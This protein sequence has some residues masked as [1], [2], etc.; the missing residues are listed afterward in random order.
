M[1]EWIDIFDLILT[2]IY[3]IIILFI[4]YVYKNFRVKSVKEEEYKYFMPALICKV[5]GAISICL[6]YTFYYTY[7]GD[8]T[9]YF[10]TSKT[11]VNTLYSGDFELFTNM[12]NVYDN[13]LNTG[14]LQKDYGS[15]YF[16]HNDYYALF[17]S[18]LIIPFCILGAKT[19]IPTTLLLSC[20]SFIGVWK[21]YRVFIEQFPNLKKEFAIGILFMP[22]V[23]FWGS[24]LLK[25]TFAIAC[26]GFY[27][28]GIYNFFI[29]NNKNMKYFLL[30]SF[31]SILILFIKPYILM[32]LLP[33][34]LI[35]VNFNRIQNVK[36]PFLRIF[37]TPFLLVF[38]VGLIVLFFNYAGNY[39]GEYSI[40]NVLNKAVKTQRDLVR[41]QY[42]S[43]FYDIGE[44]DATWQ[45][46]VS[47]IPAALNLA[48]FRPYIWDVRNPVMLLSA[49]EN[50]FMLLFSLYILFKV[51]ITTLFSSMFSHP[52]LIFSML[53]ALFF[54]FS[55]GLTTANY[56]ALA[57]L[58][59]PCIPFYIS[60]L[61]MLFELNRKSFR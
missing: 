7:G 1:P 61:Y 5:I 15:I 41:S 54:A 8:T 19:F 47:K 23:F 49:L 60:M 11:Y 10:L 17:T 9:N 42:G 27:T 32:A 46:I 12:L 38:F 24:G 14:I 31:T 55:V 33:G 58:R 53:F 21:L 30:L 20:F 6:V 25:D 34:S 18:T 40:D 29:L 45:G 51:K 16:N 3:I 35:W 28:Y 22:S 43:N 52:L 48:L 13:I 56:G 4:G 59:I 26:I 44:F 36:S 39:L 37:I 2:P 50:S 57:R